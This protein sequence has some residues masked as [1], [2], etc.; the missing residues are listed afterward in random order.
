MRPTLQNVEGAEIIGIVGQVGEVARLRG[1]S[2]IL[3][4]C[5]IAGIFGRRR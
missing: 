1:T 3:V 4:D 2:D 5:A